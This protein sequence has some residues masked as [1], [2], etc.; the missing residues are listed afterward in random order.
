MSQRVFMHIDEYGN[1]GFAQLPQFIC[2][3][4]P[5]VLWAPSARLLESANMAGATDLTWKDIIR[6]IDLEDAP[7]RV[8]GREHW[9]DRHW[10]DK[11]PWSGAHWVRTYDDTLAKFAEEDRRLAL[12]HRRVIIADRE[13]GQEK[14][15]DLLGRRGLVVAYCSIFAQF[16]TFGSVVT[17]LPLYMKSQGMEVFHVGLSLATFSVV[18]VILQFPSGVLSD[19]VG[20]LVP[21]SSALILSIV[22]LVIMPSAKVFPLLAAVMALYGAAYGMLFPSISA[23]VADHTTSEERGMATG[24]FHALLTAGVAIGAPVMGWVGGMVGVELGLTLSSGIMALALVLALSA[25]KRI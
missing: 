2:V 8:I 3:S 12:E 25:A 1:D 15:K 18:F 20:R 10:R 11:Q 6:L 16:F 14:A 17:L 5:V 22:S 24:I 13:A 19:R 21:T 4:N 23:L 9:F 7:V